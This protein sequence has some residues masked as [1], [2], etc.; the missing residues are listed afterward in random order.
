M[1]TTEDQR[2]SLKA[3]QRQD[4]KDLARDLGLSINKTVALAVRSLRGLIDL[5]M[6]VAD[7]LE[8]DLA[9][10]YRRLAREAPAVLVG[11]SATVKPGW[12][13]KRRDQPTVWVDG[14]FVYLDPE[15]DE[16]MAVNEKSGELARVVDG[17]LRPVPKPSVAQ[18]VL[19]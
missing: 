7:H 16:L 11:P 6:T 1:R 3:D 2:L 19:A 12:T 17:E 5:E 18:A 13:N 14:W 8:P 10:L 15:T 9:D 4:L